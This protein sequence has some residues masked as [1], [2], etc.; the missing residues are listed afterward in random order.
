M[1]KKIIQ[2]ALKPSLLIKSIRYHLIHSISNYNYKKFKILVDSDLSSLVNKVSNK[3]SIPIDIVSYS[4]SKDFY[5]QIYSILSFIRY[6]GKPLSWTIYS[7]GSHSQSQ[8]E[9]LEREFEFLK[10]FFI[11]LDKDNELRKTLKRELTPYFNDL[12]HF[13][14]NNVLGKKLFHYLNHNINHP[15]LFIDSDVI[16]YGNSYEFL[17]LTNQKEFCNGWYIVDHNDSSLDTRYLRNNTKSLASVNSGFF[18][19]FKNIENF[20]I[21]MDFLKSTNQYYEYFTEQTFIHLLLKSNS[22]LPL[23]S[24]YFILNSKD[25]YFFSNFYNPNEIVV[26]HYTQ[27]IRH[28]LWQKKYTWHLGL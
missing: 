28:K 2:F 13:A 18:L 6:N 27:P 7:D 17:K 23:P 8:I 4:S 1:L 16:F 25:N 5:L 15:T 21:A 11:A 12:L 24:S 3:N 20:K 10:V 26:R 22:F 9:K 19:T 14:Q